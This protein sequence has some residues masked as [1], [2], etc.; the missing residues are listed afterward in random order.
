MDIDGLGERLARQLVDEG[1][2]HEVTD[3]YF[4]TAEQLLPLDGF[5][6]KKVNNLLAAIDASRS[7][8]LPRVLTALG[9]GGVGGTVAVLLTDHYPSIDALAQAPQENLEAI[10]GLGP[11]TAGAIV[12]F[13]A[14]E[15]NRVLIDKLRR[16]DVNLEAEKKAQASDKLVG[17]TFVLTGTLPTMS[18]NEAQALIEAHGGRVTGSVSQKTSYVVAGESPGSKL[19]K[20]QSLRVPVIDEDGLKAL[21]KE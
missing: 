19:D 3:L 7:R 6:E 1:L 20:A 15:R 12:E 17:L 9:I 10:E 13:F 21:L 8:P 2:L 11:H 18:R 4:L 5:A 16:G 14:D